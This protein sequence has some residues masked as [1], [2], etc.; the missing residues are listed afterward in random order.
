MTDTSPYDEDL[1]VPASLDAAFARAGESGRRVLVVMGGAWC[2]DCRVLDAMMGATIVAPLLA[3]RYET[4]KFSVGRYDRNLASVERLGA[5]PLTGAPA[6]L[7]FTPR[8]EAVARAEMYAW[9]SARTRRP[10]ELALALDALS[11]AAPDPADTVS[12][13]GA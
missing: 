3:D 8:G 2:P 1:D 4:V 9:R 6:L 11:R 7:V 5:A 12:T 13:R 10:S